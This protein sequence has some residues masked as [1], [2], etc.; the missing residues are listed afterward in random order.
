MK[1]HP[2]AKA[3]IMGYADAGTGNP[4]INRNISQKRADR[5]AK[6][7]VER[8][9]ISADRLTTGYKGDS[10]QPFKD[11]DSNRVVIGVA[12]ETK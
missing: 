3:E 4:T 2:S 10:V 6:F 12:K 7:L 11:N 1:Q 9:G 5:V 8:Y